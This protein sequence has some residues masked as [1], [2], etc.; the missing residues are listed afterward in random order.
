MPHADLWQLAVRLLQ[1]GL[2]AVLYF[3]TALPGQPGPPSS[4]ASST[5]WRATAASTAPWRR[6]PR[7]DRPGA[8]VGA[9]ALY[10]A[11]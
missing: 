11:A 2:P 10:G 5:S 8:V 4:P 9:R 7:P 3:Q 6:A 1:A